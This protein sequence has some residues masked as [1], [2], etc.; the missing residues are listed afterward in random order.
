MIRFQY[1]FFNKTILFLILIYSALAV[2]DDYCQQPNEGEGSCI[3]MQ[4]TIARM[5]ISCVK[6][7]KNATAELNML[8]QE[9][10]E[11]GVQN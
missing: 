2:A 4:A 8:R 1:C 11:C 6:E 9:L 3:D 7:L 5:L 10:K